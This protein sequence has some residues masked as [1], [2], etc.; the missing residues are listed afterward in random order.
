M[1]KEEMLKALEE[2]QDPL[3]V[4]IRK[5]EDIVDEMGIDMHQENC[6]LCHVFLGEEPNHCKKC[7]VSIESKAPFC[8]NTPYM[9]FLDGGQDI[10]DAI[11]ILLYLENI[12]RNLNKV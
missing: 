7:P 2:G 3:A 5:W 4:S 9:S 1:T 12:Q 6:A 8:Y 11:E 10:E